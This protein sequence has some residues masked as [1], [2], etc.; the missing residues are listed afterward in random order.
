MAAKGIIRTLSD[1]A[2]RT[3]VAGHEGVKNYRL[4]QP[5]P[6]GA[7]YLSIALDDMAPGGAVAPHHHVDAPTFDHA[8]YVV[9]GQVLVKLGDGKEQLVGEGTVIYCPSDV[10]HSLKNVGKTDAKVLRIGASATGEQGR[11]VHP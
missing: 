9:S 11:T 6:D 3:G 10:T 8:F 5:G 4:L 1:V 7:L 2:A